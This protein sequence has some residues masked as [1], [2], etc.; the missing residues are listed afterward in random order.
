[1]NYFSYPHIT[2][3]VRPQEPIPSAMSPAV[4]GIPQEE[5]MTQSSLLTCNDK[6][7]K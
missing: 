7:Y 5:D 6:H 4:F 1:M 2:A 3:G